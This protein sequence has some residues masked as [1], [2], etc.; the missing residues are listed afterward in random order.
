[1]IS[2]NT[3]LLLAL[4]AYSISFKIAAG[5][6]SRHPYSNPEQENSLLGTELSHRTAR[7]FYKTFE[8]TMATVIVKARCF[9]EGGCREGI[10]WSRC[11]FYPFSKKMVL[12]NQTWFN[13]HWIRRL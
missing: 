1:M 3:L 9:G 8:D 6:P 10:C 4:T 7:K 11:G 2:K 5:H 13:I 12:Y